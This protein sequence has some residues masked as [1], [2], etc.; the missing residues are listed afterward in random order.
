[1]F[2]EMKPVSRL[3]IELKYDNI[4]DRVLLKLRWGRKTGINPRCIK[5]TKI[6]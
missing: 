3:G 2:R 6:Y 5:H 1:L 4:R